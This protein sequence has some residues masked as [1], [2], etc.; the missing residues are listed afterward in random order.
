MTPDPPAR[1]RAALLGEI[2]GRAAWVVIGCLVCQLGL[3]FG[4]ALAPLA[5]D[6]L[7]EFGWTRAQ[8]SGARLPQ[9]L[10]TS[11]TSPVLGW[12][13]VRFGVRGILI[14]ATVVL[15]ISFIGLSGVTG[16]AGYYSFIIVMGL[17]V[18]GLGDITVGAAVSNWVTRNRGVALGIVYTGSNL[19]GWLLTRVADAIAAQ[20]GW[21][22]ALF[23][24]GAGGAAF[25]LPFAV[26]AVR[27][28]PAPAAGA[29]SGERAE[30]RL[31]D[32][33]LP[34]A[35]AARTRSFWI[36]TLG[37]FVFFFYFLGMIE[38][39]VLFMTD[40][41]M[42]REDAA[43]YF[44]TAIGL[45]I[46]S[47]LGAGWLA[48]RISRATLVRLDFGLL[49]AS[50]GVLLALP[51]AR[52]T[53]VFVVCYGFATAARDIVYP[54]AIQHCFGDRYMAEIYGAMMV[55][56]VLGGGAG[57]FFAASVFDRTGSY[58]IAFGT[59]AAL[60]AALFAA[61]LFLRD[62]RRVA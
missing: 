41:G 34:L 49:A 29:A 50:A 45:G 53:W 62:E 32:P 61:C 39:F 46:A 5:K 17:S 36:L 16:L 57:P 37:L 51:D 31:V 26:F 19:G 15:G 3:G 60:T 40:S 38:H 18:T 52:L 25:I 8:L 12:M 7:A 55:V 28:R 1:E 35:T 59:F 58:A 24:I 30:P 10:A 9:L 14:A 23:W 11:L 22:T 42:P 2:R 47:K 56:L 54:L 43:F 48:D 27:G 21:R 13:V 20:A 33:S 6:I 44:S 4:Y